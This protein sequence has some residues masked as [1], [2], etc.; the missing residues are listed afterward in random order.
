V[1][2]AIVI[3]LLGVTASLGCGGGAS[4]PNPATTLAIMRKSEEP[5]KLLDEGKAFA[6]MGDTSRAEQYFS[7][8]ITHGAD[9]ALV[10]PLLVK[11]CVRDGRYELAIDYAARY[12]QKHPNDTRM[13]Y[14]LGTLYAAIGD[15]SHA[16][17]ELEYVVLA[18]PD[19]PEPHWALAKVLQEQDKDPTSADGQ[20][21]EYLRLAPTGTHAEEARAS[22][23]KEEHPP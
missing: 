16:R 6:Q 8:A 4:N 20:F 13:R 10:V 1:P 15:G 7:A 3:G 5:Q 2:R 11:V 17:H 23:T 14:L 18:K 9:E 19:D 22:I 21:R 12:A